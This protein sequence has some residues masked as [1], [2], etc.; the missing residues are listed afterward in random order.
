M[1]AGFFKGVIWELKTEALVLYASVVEP[2]EH[3][4]FS[5]MYLLDE[6]YQGKPKVELNSKRTLLLLHPQPR[7][8]LPICLLD[9][10]LYCI[11]EAD[12]KHQ[13]FPASHFHMLSTKQNKNLLRQGQM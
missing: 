3:D 7:P 6:T 8:H 13:I 10:R 4:Y 11:F 1:A 12:L 9:R 2:N 5:C